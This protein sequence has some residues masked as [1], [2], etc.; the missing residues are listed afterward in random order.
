MLW[1]EILSG[2]LTDQQHYKL[3]LKVNDKERMTNAKHSPKNFQFLSFDIN[4]CVCQIHYGL[5]TVYTHI[6]CLD[7]LFLTTH[8]TR[9]SVT[10]TTSS[11]AT[12]PPPTPA[13]IAMT[14]LEPFS[15]LAPP[16]TTIR[17]M[18]LHIIST[19]GTH[20]AQ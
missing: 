2:T 9:H 19:S 3:L 8:T 6:P 14:F 16:T 10:T 11:T 15:G 12:P 7:L 4:C 1:E 20:L 13:A 17:K 5:K 18:Y